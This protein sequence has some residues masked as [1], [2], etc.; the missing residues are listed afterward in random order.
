MF[1]KKTVTQPATETEFP[2]EK[3]EITTEVS[4][5][6][7]NPKVTP[8]TSAPAVNQAI[9]SAPEAMNGEL[10]IQRNI[11]EITTEIILQKSQIVQSFIEI[12]KLLIEAKKQ[13]DDGH[14]HWLKWLSTSV[15]ISV[16]M[17]QRYMQL[18][19]EYSNTTSVTDLG[20]TKAL[21]LLAL[22]GN[23]RETF[24][25]ESHEVNGKQKHV[26]EM[27]TREIK[28]AIREKKEA[29]EKHKD[30]V[31]A[32]IRKD[33]NKIICPDVKQK[34]DKSS[35]AS[36]LLD[37]FIH[38]LESVQSHLDCII[39]FLAKQDKNPVVLDK[40][41]DELCSL[42]DKTL[43]CLSLAKLEVS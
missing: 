17:A 6:E 39:D 12:G 8:N 43:K 27:S 37:N 28:N 2:A 21:A 5:V 26:R 13:L 15:D 31:F 10:Q 32:P 24:I 3:K 18:A 35:E 22:P 11:E 25:N 16:R 38:E 29:I 30:G 42:H 14:G 9:D 41:A 19:K 7:E 34:A 40:Y 36:G 20:M 33:G 4:N 23:E 1:D